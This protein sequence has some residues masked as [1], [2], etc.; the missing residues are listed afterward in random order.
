MAVTLTA[1]EL[2]VAVRAATLP[3]GIEDEYAADIT[4]LLA[5][6]AAIVE[7]RAPAAPSAVANEAV[8]RIAGHLLDSPAD[9]RTPQTAFYSSGASEIL[10]HFVIRRAEAV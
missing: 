9:Q 7:A 5:T 8:I 1:V 4:R 6:G 3:G 2:A 10:S